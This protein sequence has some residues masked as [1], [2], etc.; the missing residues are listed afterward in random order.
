MSTTDVVPLVL[1]L[2]FDSGGLKTA[3]TSGPPWACGD[4][5]GPSSG[6]GLAAGEGTGS[7]G[8]GG[9]CVP[10]AGGGGG[11]GLG[12]GRAPAGGDTPGA[13]DGVSS[14]PNS[15][16]RAPCTRT[17]SRVPMFSAARSSSVTL[18]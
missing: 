5:G 10:E 13:G 14:G 18:G 3:D 12:P 17:S 6:D 2:R 7:C 11:V 15:G 1:T 16:G 9:I 8:P 4:G